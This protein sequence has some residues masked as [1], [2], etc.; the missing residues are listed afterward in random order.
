M[1]GRTQTLDFVFSLFQESTR[2]AAR[3][4]DPWS[5]EAKKQCFSVPWSWCHSWRNSV[6]PVILCQMLGVPLNDAVSGCW[7]E[8]ELLVSM[9]AK[10]CKHADYLNLSDSWPHASAKLGRKGQIPIETS[11]HWSKWLRHPIKRL[12]DWVKQ[13]GCMM[14]ARKIPKTTWQRKK[15]WSCAS[16]YSKI[17]NRKKAGMQNR[18]NIYDM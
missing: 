1:L 4:G 9:S 6:T 7:V 13:S 5:F 10:P 17:Q 8:T 16:M 15:F 14:I 3:K 11:R 2:K 18:I 12:S